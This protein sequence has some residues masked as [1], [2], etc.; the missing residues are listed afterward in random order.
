MRLVVDVGNTNVKFGFYD[1]ETCLCVLNTTTFKGYTADEYYAKLNSI[2]SD[3]FKGFEDVT[4]CFVSSVVPEVN[5]SLSE[6]ISK[7]M[8]VTPVFLEVG[9]KTGIG[10]KVKSPQEVGSDLISAAAG[11]IAK[12]MFPVIIVGIGTATTFTIVNADKEIIGVSI[13]PGLEISKRALASKTSLLKQ[14]ELKVPS[15]ILGRNTTES[16]QSGIVFGH[17]SMIDGMICRIQEAVDYNFNVIA[18]GGLSNL[19]VPLCKTKIDIDENLLLSGLNYIGGL[20]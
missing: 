19:I 20:N 8:N 14:I 9:V 1:K 2:F 4:T 10:V 6:A 13:A 16:M 12:N 3:S 7:L 5:R 11:A 15:S 17:A 18:F